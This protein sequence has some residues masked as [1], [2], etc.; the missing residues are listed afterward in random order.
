MLYSRFDRRNVPL[1]L[2]KIFA[3]IIKRFFD[4]TIDKLLSALII[5]PRRDNFY[6]AFQT[7]SVKTIITVS[8]NH[9]KIDF[10]PWR[11]KN[12]LAVSA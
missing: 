12:C 2:I 3:L 9:R 8:L 1:F 10:M 11:Q 4:K 6:T 5:P 7:L